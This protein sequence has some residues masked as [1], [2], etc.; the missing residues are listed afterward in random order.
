VKTRTSTVS[1][2]STVSVI[3][4]HLSDGLQS[5]VARSPEPGPPTIFPL[6]ADLI[7]LTGRPQRRRSPSRLTNRN[8]RPSRGRRPSPPTQHPGGPHVRRY[9][10][11]VPTR[12]TGPPARG[13]QSTVTDSAVIIEHTVHDRPGFERQKCGFT[14]PR[15][16]TTTTMAA[17]A[18]RDAGS[19]GRPLPAASAPGL[20]KSTGSQHL[21][22]PTNNPDTYHLSF[23]RGARRPPSTGFSA[24]VRSDTHNI[25]HICEVAGSTR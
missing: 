19:A 22:V 2:P 24:W 20:T 18:M 23:K 8:R 17:G 15:G 3:R 14:K 9:A 25:R 10:H 4:I 13:R 5:G 16:Q 7:P 21:T 6:V 1:L 11:R 12:L